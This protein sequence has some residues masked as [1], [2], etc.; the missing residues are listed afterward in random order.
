MPDLVVEGEERPLDLE[1]ARTA[2]VIAIA[3]EIAAERGRDAVEL[4]DLVAAHPEWA[5]GPR[6]VVH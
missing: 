3:R 2:D 1:A 5:A 6:A 4:E